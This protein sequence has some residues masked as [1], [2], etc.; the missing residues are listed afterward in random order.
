MNDRALTLQMGS[1]SSLWGKNIEGS[2][3]ICGGNMQRTS[4]LGLIPPHDDDDDDDTFI[5]VHSLGFTR[6]A[7]FHIVFRQVSQSESP[8]CG[9]GCNMGMMWRL[10]QVVFGHNI[11]MMMDMMWHQGGLSS[12]M[13]WHNTSS[14]LSIFFFF[15]FF[16][17]KQGFK[18]FAHNMMMM[19]MMWHQGWAFSRA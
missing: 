8:R 16:F 19:D 9:R 7:N 1:A 12:G 18:P 5:S 4:P 14:C 10:F 2:T 13:M 17:F 11:C 3:P 6:C 15:F